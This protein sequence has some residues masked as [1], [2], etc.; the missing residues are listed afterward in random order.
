M[1]GVPSEGP[2]DYNENAT[3]SAV[4]CD[5]ASV[6]PGRSMTWITLLKILRLIMNNEA[7]LVDISK[8]DEKIHWVNL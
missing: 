8:E 2:V 5:L 3:N 1:T 4:A 7:E 6:D